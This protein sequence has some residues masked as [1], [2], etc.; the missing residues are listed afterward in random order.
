M[1][2]RARYVWV[3]TKRRPDGN[4]KGS[5]AVGGAEALV[6]ELKIA[7]GKAGVDARVTS[8][9]CFDLCWVGPAVGVM[10]DMTFFGGMSSEDIPALV[11]A[12]KR[13]ENVASCP[14]LAGKVVRLEQFE[15]PHKRREE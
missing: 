12:L 4:P 13:P 2:K 1:S 6:K 8:S 3:C 11:E 14:A 10:P 5:C 7:A 15:D 9:G